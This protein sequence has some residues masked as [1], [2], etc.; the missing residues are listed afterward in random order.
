MESFKG[1]LRR[2]PFYF[3]FDFLSQ[4]TKVWRGAGAA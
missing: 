4:N 2:L 1:S 3:G